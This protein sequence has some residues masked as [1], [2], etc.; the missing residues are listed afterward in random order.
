MRK[1]VLVIGAATLD[2]SL[3]VEKYPKADTKDRCRTIESGGGNAAN[4]AST[5]GRL[6]LL[7]SSG[8]GTNDE[9][10]KQFGNKNQLVDNDFCVQLLT[11]ISRDEIGQSIMKEL[12]SYG[13]D[14]SSPLLVRTDETLKSQVVTVIVTKTPPTRTCL[15]DPGTVGT[16]EPSDLDQ[17][18]IRDIMTDVIHYH[19]DTRHTEVAVELARVAKTFTKQKLLISVDVERDRFSA[20][21]DDLIDLADTV[22]TNSNLMGPILTRR[23]NHDPYQN[24]EIQIE[25]MDNTATARQFDDFYFNVVLLH[26]YLD[27]L[28][29]KSMNASG[30]GG[31]NSEE[32]E[33]KIIATR[34]VQL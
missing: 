3:Y 30:G 1:V 13:V 10:H 12:E 31:E 15:F 21:F 23:L 19:S 26:H 9:E 20:E 24:F 27:E 32:T 6:L 28:R 2:R 33:R 4:T 16:L 14:T 8:H 7:S 18:N 5:L 34:Y 11:K 25:K 17:I 22:F 29:L